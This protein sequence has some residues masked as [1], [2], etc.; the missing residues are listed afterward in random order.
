MSNKDQDFTKEELELEYLCQDFSERLGEYI[1]K[2]N[3][4]GFNSIT[5]KSCKKPF[6]KYRLFKGYFGANGNIL[7]TPNSRFRIKFPFSIHWLQ[8][9]LN[10][11]LCHNENGTKLLFRK[12][13]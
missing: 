1:N 12:N 13:Y 4:P 2:Y 9:F 7:T 6:P 11:Y 8:E 10:E 3:H 5:F